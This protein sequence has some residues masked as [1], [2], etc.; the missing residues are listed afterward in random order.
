MRILLFFLLISSNLFAGKP[1]W[2]PDYF[3]HYEKDPTP[4]AKG[5]RIKIICEFDSDYN[6]SRELRLGINGSDE[7]IKLNEKNECIVIRKPQKSVFQFFYDFNFQEIETDTIEI[8]AGQI[9]I[10]S[11]HFKDQNEMRPVKKPVIYLYPES[12]TEL[13]VQLKT[14]GDL[15]FSYPDY[16][17]GWKGTAHPDGS[18]DI[19]GTHYPYLFWES[20]QRFNSFDSRLGGFVINRKN[21]V[22][23]LEKHLTDLGFNDKEKTD[24]ITFWG[25]QL[26]QYEEVM[27]QFVL[28][29]ACDEFATLE[30]EPKPAHLN[31]VYMI[32]AH[33]TPG[34]VELIKPQILKKLDRTGFDVLEWGG[35]ELVGS[36]TDN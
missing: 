17:K 14:K 24:F 12:D 30:I 11:L 27:I 28:N 31:R 29:D 3:V 35:I 23:S 5:A 22:E 2:I 10:I 4:S 19:D 16:S 6:P 25:P 9:T 34:E 8:K 21:V 7:L 18:I 20:E 36:A 26:Q 1:E 13:S 32:W 33:I 15:T